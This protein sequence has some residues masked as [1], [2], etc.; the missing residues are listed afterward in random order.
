ME[1]PVNLS[2]Q[3]RHTWIPSPTVCASVVTWNGL[4][5][6]LQGSLIARLVTLAQCSGHFV[7]CC[8]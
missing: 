2:Q 1:N 7:I 8:R 6:F 4:D 3:R 5:Q